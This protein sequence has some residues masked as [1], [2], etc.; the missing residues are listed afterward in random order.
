MLEEKRAK[1]SA[2]A[3]RFEQDLMQFK[4]DQV[5]FNSLYKRQGHNFS[6]TVLYVPSSSFMCRTVSTVRK[7]LSQLKKDQGT[8]DLL[9][10]RQDQHVSLSQG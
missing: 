10:G 4:K 5:A 1:A 7:E 3:Q 2:D 9:P 8:L 6:L